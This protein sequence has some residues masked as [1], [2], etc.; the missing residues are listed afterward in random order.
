M[1]RFVDLPVDF[2]CPHRHGCPYLEGLSTGWVFRRYQEV[3]GT[4]CQYEYQLEQLRQ[5]LD[6]ER[7]QRQHLEHEKQQIQAQLQALHRRQFKRRRKP[8]AGGSEGPPPERKKR[9]APVGH[10][11]WR[12]RR[13]KQ[14]DFR[15]DMPAPQCCPECQST[16]LEP[17]A[18]LRE[19]LQEDIVLEPRVVVTN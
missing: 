17:V 13:P 8:P 5:E 6:E 9:G 15:F 7:R 11:G 4:E 14:I 10:P 18:E 1:P 12:R 16:D 3:S 19:H 2:C